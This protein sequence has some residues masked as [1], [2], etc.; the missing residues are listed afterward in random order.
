MDECCSI[1]QTVNEVCH[2]TFY[3]PIS[4]NLKKINDFDESVQKLFK[5]RVSN[6]VSSVCEYREKNIY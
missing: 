4:R 2:K 1:G 5:L 3:G 6:A